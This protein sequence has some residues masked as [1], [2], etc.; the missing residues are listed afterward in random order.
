MS[1]K[2]LEKYA[3]R[4]VDAL[5]GEPEGDAEDLGAFGFLRGMQAR[6]IMVELRRRGGETLA[7]AYGFID[8]VHLDPSD[9]ITLYCG[10]RTIT[11]RGKNLNYEIRPNFTLFRALI[12]ARA[13]WL[14]ETDQSAMLQSGTHA[15]VIEAI[16][17]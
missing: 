3:T 2:L 12:C 16:E 17:W 10:R 14:A 9:S 13:P 4:P 7:V 6:S 5:A 1:G 11:I 8:R 15:V